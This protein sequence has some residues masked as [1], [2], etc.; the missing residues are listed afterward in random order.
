MRLAVWLVISVAACVDPHQV[1]CGDGV[2]CPAG[3]TC[4]PG[5]CASPEQIAACDPPPDNGTCTVALGEGR[6]VDGLCVV[7]ICGNGVV[8]LDEVCDDANTRSFDGCSSKCDSLEA[9]GNGI[10]ELDED[11]DGTP[12]CSVACKREYCGNGIVDPREVCDD[13]NDVESDTCSA[14]CRSDN[15]C[16]NGITDY[17]VAE[18][19]DD[20]NTIP[21]DGCSIECGIELQLWL[22]QV[23]ASV[24]GRRAPALAYDAGRRRMV[25]FGGWATGYSG[26]TWEYDGT[27]WIRMNPIDSPPAREQTAMAYDAKRGRIVMYGGISST[28]F[29]DTW[30]YDGITWTRRTLPASPG[31]RRSHAMTYDAARERIVMFGG[32]SFSGGT[33]IRLNDTW[34]YDG[35]TWTHIQTGANKPAPRQHHAMTYDAARG[36]IVLYGGTQNLSTELNDTW[37]YASGTWTERNPPN[38]VGL[39]RFSHT[40]AYDAIRQTVVLYGGISLTTEQP[41]TWEYNGTTWSQLGN[42]QP[43]RSEHAMAYDVSRGRMVVAGGLGANNAMINETAEH[44]SSSGWSVRSVSTPSARALHAMVYDTAR[45]RTVLFGGAD[46]N[47]TL[48]PAETWELSGQYWI[49]SLSSGPP[50]A[51]QGLSLAFDS[52]RRKVVLFGGKGSSG[53]LDDT[54]EYDG[55]SW[56]QPTTITT[57]PSPRWGHGTAYDV[58]RGKLV[59]FGGNDGSDDTFF[60][61]TWEF[62]GTNW[63]QV[64]PASSP[65]PRAF[66]A[67]TY[68]VTRGTVV[69]VAGAAGQVGY[70]DTWEYNGTTWTQRALTNFPPTRMQHSLTYDV[71][72]SRLVLFGG[73]QRFLLSALDDGSNIDDVWELDGVTW[74]EYTPIALLPSPS[75]RRAAA[76]VYDTSRQHAV[77]F[78]GS[79]GGVS[80]QTWTFGFPDIVVAE[81]CSS[82]IDYDGDGV[83]GCADSDCWGVCTPLCPPAVNVAT[84]PA[85]STCG[86]GVCTVVED[87][88]SCPADCTTADPGCPVRCGDFF[89]DSP[90]SAA[91][92]PGDC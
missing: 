64:S 73:T 22:P 60:A 7:A 74:R 63:I 45:G 65:P 68:D 28:I 30:E 25:L 78:G 86:D 62:D 18:Q 87:C 4:V 43:P 69:L 34:E 89:C 80:S 82:G 72:R 88:R 16:G 54:W 59:L 44:D 29:N 84:C 23:P 46:D 91:T 3:Y 75:D 11:C 15:S 32:G 10:V 50:V 52:M 9:C 13:G 56:S 6:C 58:K 36:V 48:M 76:L 21:N 37:V 77:L 85:T 39:G 5:G 79:A 1:E 71:G 35:T 67:M 61:D 66:H 55:T 42:H 51:R 12:G 41:T 14:A 57:A 20:G 26:E 92:C 40:M 81:A 33:A 31:Y 83:V 53:L 8:E 27:G 49:R 19:C 38:N 24:I 2:V 70:N 90:E 17:A 47:G